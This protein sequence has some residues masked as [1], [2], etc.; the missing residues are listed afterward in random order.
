MKPNI[1]SERMNISGWDFYALLQATELN[2]MDIEDH[3]LQ[4]EAVFKE[5]LHEVSVIDD[6]RRRFK[7]TFERRF[8][9]T[10]ERIDFFII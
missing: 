10:F 5:L 4:V 8:K 7:R 9:R 1:K 2:E 3:E 6:C